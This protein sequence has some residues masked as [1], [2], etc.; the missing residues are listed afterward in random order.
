[1]RLSRTCQ[2][3]S[4][5]ARAAG[6]FLTT[7]F[8]AVRTMGSMSIAFLIRCCSERSMDEMNNQSRRRRVYSRSE[9]VLVAKAGLW[10]RVSDMV[11]CIPLAAYMEW[12]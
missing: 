2:S 12:E 5:K 8:N 4:L 1:M 10:D 3:E 7:C 9:L 6:P 11:M